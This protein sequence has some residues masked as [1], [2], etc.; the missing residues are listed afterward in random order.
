M[1]DIRDNLITRI[2]IVAMPAADAKMATLF[3]SILA[4]DAATR[5]T[6]VFYFSDAVCQYLALN[7]TIRAQLLG[8]MCATPSYDANSYAAKYAQLAAAY[9]T[10]SLPYLVAGGFNTATCSQTYI[11][12]YSPMA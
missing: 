7:P 3:S 8:S 5:K 12:M 2:I 1:I 4:L 9:N 6:L 10:A 11:D